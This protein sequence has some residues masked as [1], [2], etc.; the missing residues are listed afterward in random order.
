MAADALD[1]IYVADTDHSKIVKLYFNQSTGTINFVSSFSV[2]GLIRAVDIAIDQSGT[3]STPSQPQNDRIWIADDFT[4]QLIAVGRD[5]V[6]KQRITQYYV[7]AT[8]YQL[9]APMKVQF[10]EQGGR[11]AFI[12]R[13]R[14]AF[15]TVYPP[16]PV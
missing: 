6:V 10:Q 5:G 14:L 9:K 2:P 8:L 3:A 13:A 1:T 7:G 16:T 4:G 12:D 15:V 11:L